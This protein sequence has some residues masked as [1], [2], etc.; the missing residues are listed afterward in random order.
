M[1]TKIDYI[2]FVAF[3]EEIIKNEVLSNDDKLKM[4]ESAMQKISANV[5]K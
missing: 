1:A 2:V 3:V 4:I 5:E